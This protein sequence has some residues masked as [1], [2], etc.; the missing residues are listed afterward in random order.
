MSSTEVGRYFST[1][2]KVSASMVFFFVVVLGG[3]AVLLPEEDEEG[4]W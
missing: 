2:G 1:H 3:S 4:E